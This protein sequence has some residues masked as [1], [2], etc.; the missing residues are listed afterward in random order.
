MEAICPTFDPLHISGTDAG[1]KACPMCKYGYGEGIMIW[2]SNLSVST[3]SSFAIMLE[4]EIQK[5]GL[6]NFRVFLVYM[7]PVSEKED[8]TVKKLIS[9]A[10]QMN[11]RN[12]AATMVPSCKR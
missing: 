7:K 10:S 1:K 9:W 11:L 12:V 5:R 2:I 3:L 8:A 6:R 4:N